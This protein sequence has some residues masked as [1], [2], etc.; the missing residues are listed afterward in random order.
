MKYWWLNLLLLSVTIGPVG[1][2]P[3]LWPTNASR[4]ITSTFG[5][6][7]EGHLHSGIDIKT[8]ARIG[9]RVFAVADGYVWRVRVSPYGYGKG[10]YLKLDDGRFAVYGHLARFNSRINDLILREQKKLGGYSVDLYLEKDELRVRRWEIVAFTGQTGAK[11][12][13]LH[14]E[15]RDS[16]QNPLNPLT[17]G[18]T[19][20]DTIS[21]VFTQIAFTPVDTSFRANGSY[22]LKIYDLVR[23]GPNHFL[24]PDTVSLW[25]RAGLAIS[26]YDQAQGR[27]NRFSVYRLLLFVDGEEI[28][29]SGYESFP[30]SKTKMVNLDRDY[31]LIRIY[32]ETFQRLFIARGNQLPFYDQRLSGILDP[33]SLSPGI[34]E[35]RVQAEDI[36]GNLATLNGVFRMS[37][38]NPGMDTDITYFDGSGVIEENLPENESVLMVKKT[39]YD[40]YLSLEVTSQEPLSE[41]PVLRVEAENGNMFIRAKMI[42]DTHFIAKIPLSEGMGNY[43]DL[44]VVGVNHDGKVGAYSERTPIFPIPVNGG[45]L[46]AAEGGDFW[47]EFDGHSLYQILYVRLKEMDPPRDDP[48]KFVG[49]LFK[50]DPFDVPLKDKVR[51]AFRCPKDEK[52]PVQLGVYYLD[53]KRGW[54]FLGNDFDFD[55]GT[56]LAL[57]PS[58]ETFALIRDTEGPILSQTLPRPGA[59]IPTLRPYIEVAIRDDGSGVDHRSIQVSLDGHRLIPAYDPER[60]RLFYRVRKNLKRTR[61]LLNVR[62]A[63]RCGNVSE[64]EGW[65]VIQ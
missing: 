17:L 21:P 1:A 38:P 58:L 18:F 54:T 61:H 57:S 2:E 23:K 16:L 47:V 37:E 39:F 34:H 63:D 11:V 12:P 10:L 46:V 13:H 56:L 52:N 33:E 26:G 6:Y 65:F 4:L 14:F 30:F 45:G 3:Y 28:F 22:Q 44:L 43:L 50:V 51:V 60:E 59:T 48:Q 29:R 41:A 15:I 53:S 5:E 49:S 64:L 20:E 55:T 25:G 7:R 35:F 32:D 40:D 42:D 27:F 19:I 8:W 24:L 9:Y 62:A 36:C 31:R